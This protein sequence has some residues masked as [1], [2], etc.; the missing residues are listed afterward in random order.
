MEDYIRMLV[1]EEFDQDALVDALRE[2]I[3]DELD[4]DHLAKFI[5]EN[6]DLDDIVT[7]IA[8]AN[9]DLPF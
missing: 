9:L 8:A 2:R 7:E 5:L 3:R 4:Y 6:V 1:E